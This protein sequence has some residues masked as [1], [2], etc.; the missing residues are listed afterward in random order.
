MVVLVYWSRTLSWLGALCVLV[1]MF[2]RK[3]K[4][5]VLL[6][7]GPLPKCDS[8]CASLSSNGILNFDLQQSTDSCPE[9]MGLIAMRM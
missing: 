7:L 9:L 5:I 6:L 8:D 4:M 2:K 3:S 1:S